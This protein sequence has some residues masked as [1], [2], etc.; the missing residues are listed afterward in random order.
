MKSDGN[1]FRTNLY[2]FH[3]QNGP[4]VE[5]RGTSPEHALNALGY[6]RG[7]ITALDYWEQVKEDKNDA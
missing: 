6:G 4:T 2:R 5:G 7:S 1:L 3:W